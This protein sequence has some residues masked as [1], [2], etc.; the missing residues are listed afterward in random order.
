MTTADLELTQVQGER[1][2]YSLEGVGTLRLEGLGSRRAT[3]EADGRRWRIARHGFWRRA[4]QA[5][6]EGDN[7]MGEF[8]PN[9]LRR[10]GAVLWHG[11]ELALRP[12]SQCRERYALAEGSRELA[13]L[14]GKSWGRRPVKVTLDDAEAI[15]TGLLLFT[16]FVVRG[17]AEDAAA[18]VAATTAA[19]SPGTSS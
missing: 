12:A 13:L 4:I 6:D 18:T 7:V 10:G 3:A 2:L 17:F 19:T 14:D 5:S 11:R 1:R 8:E 15:D 9:S 16:A